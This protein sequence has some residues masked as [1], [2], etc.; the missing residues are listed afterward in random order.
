MLNKFKKTRIRAEVC[1]QVSQRIME[2]ADSFKR[3]SM[4]DWE[5]TLKNF[6]AEKLE[7]EN[8]EEDWSVQNARENYEEGEYKLE[9]YDEIVT[10]LEKML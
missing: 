4:D 8:L 10:M 1:E 7:N 9:V 3:W 5:I 6:D 2:L